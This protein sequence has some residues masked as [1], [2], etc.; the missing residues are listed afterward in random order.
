M[1]TGLLLLLICFAT[2]SFAQ[3]ETNDHCIFFLKPKDYHLRKVSAGDNCIIGLKMNNKQIEGDIRKISYDT[4]F[5]NGMN[6][7]VRDIA[8]F[9]Y[10]NELKSPVLLTKPS[11][12]PKEFLLYSKDTIVWKPIIPPPE[13][14]SSSWAY[15]KYIRY[16]QDSAKYGGKRHAPRNPFMNRKAPGRNY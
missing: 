6:I 12:L 7:K 14:F 4:V 16:Q 13:I 9:A 5:I 2:A 8:Y 15:S 10:R 1:R 3:E 11:D